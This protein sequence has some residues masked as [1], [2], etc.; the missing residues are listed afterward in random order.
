MSRS[1]H[2]EAQMIAALKQMEAG[3]PAAEVAREV[4]VAAPTLYQ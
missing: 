1:R 3:R 4:G 2:T